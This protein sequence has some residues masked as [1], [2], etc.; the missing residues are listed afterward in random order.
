MNSWPTVLP[1]LMPGIAPTYMWRLE[2]Q[3]AVLVTRTMASPGSVR[4]GE[5]LEFN[6]GTGTSATR[7]SLAPC[8]CTAFIVRV[9]SSLGA[10]V[11]AGASSRRGIA[12]PVAREV[13]MFFG[14]GGALEA[15]A[16]LVQ[17]VLGGVEGVG[18][19]TRALERVSEE[20]KR[21]RAVMHLSGSDGQHGAGPLNVHHLSVAK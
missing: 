17:A 19:G 4:V 13:L 10:S 12:A 21:P 11:V 8:H 18:R 7:T 1:F 14:G 5:G 15:G 9:S 16:R 3:I 20:E 2:P 6:F